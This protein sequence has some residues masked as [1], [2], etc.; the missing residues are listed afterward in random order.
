M[1]RQELWSKAK[2]VWADAKYYAGFAATWVRAHPLISGGVLLFLLGFAFAGYVFAA[3]VTCTGSVP[4][5][6]NCVE[7][8]ATPPTQ[9]TPPIVVPPSDSCPA[10]TIR[11]RDQFGNTAIDTGEYGSFGGNILVVEIKVPADFSGSSQRTTSW[12][13]YGAASVVRH[14]VLS[15]KPCDFA[16]VNAVKLS[17]GAALVSHNQIRFSFVY[18]ATG[19]MYA[20]KL[21]PGQTYYLNIRNRDP[22]GNLTCSIQDCRMRGSLP[23]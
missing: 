10:D 11:I 17:S 2:D 1:N 23:K 18:S 20:A 16:P 22:A 3:Q 15:T 14:A 6:L 9:P 7:T 12:A 21:I 4:G 19:G 8:G 5:T 13:E